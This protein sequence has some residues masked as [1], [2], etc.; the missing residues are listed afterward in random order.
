MVAVSVNLTEDDVDKN[1][2]SRELFLDFSETSV[3]WV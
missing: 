2:N 1:E 3:L